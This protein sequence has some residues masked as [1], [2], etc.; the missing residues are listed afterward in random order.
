MTLT[1]ITSDGITD[2][3]VV[4]ADINASAAIAGT[5]ISPDFGSQNIVTTGQVQINGTYPLLKLHDSNSENDYSIRNNNGQFMIHDDDRNVSAF[6]ISTAGTGN[7]P[8][9]LDVGAG[10]DVTGAI[11]GTAGLSID[12]ATVFNEAGADVDF[13]IEGVNEANLFH[14]DAGNRRIG[15]I[16]S[17]PSDELHIKE[18][19]NGDVAAQI[20]NTNTGSSARARLQLSSDSASLQL[21][22]TGAAYSGVSSWSDAGVITTGSGASG[23]LILNTTA[24]GGTIKFQ[25][26]QSEKV[27]IDNSGRVGIGTTSPAA[28]L[29]VVNTSG[30]AEIICSSS[31]QPRFMLKTTG[32]TAECRIDFGDSGDSSRGA[33]GYNHNDDALKFYT[34]GVANERMRIDSA[35][36]LLLGTTT[37][38]ITAGDDLTIA[39][40]GETGITLRSGTSNNGAIYFSDGTSGADEYRGI[41]N[42]NHTNNFLTFYADASERMRIDSSGNVGIG[43]TSPSAAL[44][45]NTGASGLPKIRLQH[46]STGNDVFEIT[47]GIAG[48]SNGGFGIYDVDESAYRFAIASNGNVG[49]GTTSPDQKLHVYEQSGSSQAYIHV[50]N[51]RSRNAAIKFTTTQGSWLVGQGIGNDNDRFAIY[52]N[53]ERFVID[54]SGKIFVGVT[55]GGDANAKI[56]AK[57]GVAVD[58]SYTDYL[59]GCYEAQI[60]VNSGGQYKQAGILNVWDGNIHGVSLAAFYNGSGYGFVIAVNDDTNDRPLERFTID[61]QGTT[62]INSTSHVLNATTS[63]AAGGSSVYNF[64]GHHSGG[65]ISF[66]VWSNGNVQNTNNSYGSISDIKLKENIVDANSQWSDIKALKIRNYNFKAE[67]KHETHTQ[68]GVVAQELET[69]CPKLVTAITDTDSEGNDL[70]TTT[71]SVNYS[72]LYMKA[73]KALQEAITKIETLETK[74][75][76]LEAA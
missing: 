31:T 58:S 38:G 54:S 47:G 42:Y 5:K 63:A 30:A 44:H 25:I 4:N 27:R 48:V 23:G 75:A 46:T 18:S 8:G 14:V 33:I 24:S 51:N 69:I 34:T 11:T 57:Q 16:T 20:E 9:N 60:T 52:D 43:T 50:Q 73:I 35:G 21:Y 74:V 37:E 59:H 55:S 71:K 65:T 15:I 76:A 68:I 32:T 40:S 70:G 3:T 53:Q 64:R 29:D 26:Q 10:V 61:N 7:F 6:S 62:S 41:I 17:S 39:T 22:A 13:R 19:K 2:G 36:R 1:R 67:T 72:V 66:N 49:I 56:R 28:L 12:G 45:I